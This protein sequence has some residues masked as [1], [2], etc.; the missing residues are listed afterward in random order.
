M[1]KT[2]SIVVENTYIRN[3]GD[4][5]PCNNSSFFALGELQV[6][7]KIKGELKE[8]IKI[9]DDRYYL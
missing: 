5:P 1:L 8:E 9:K 2:L 4:F 6:S 3:K 7:E